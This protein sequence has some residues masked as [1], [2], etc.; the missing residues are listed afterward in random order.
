MFEE[1]YSVF[2]LAFFVNMTIQDPFGPRCPSG[3]RRDSSLCL[4]PC[5]NVSGLF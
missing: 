2:R 3:L 5:Y 1:A 4:P